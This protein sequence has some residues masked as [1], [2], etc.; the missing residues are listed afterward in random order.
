MKMVVNYLNFV[1]LIEVK[2]KSKNRIFYFC[3]SFYEKHKM[4]LWVHGL[5]CS[6]KT[7]PEDY[8]ENEVFF[9]SFFWQFFTS[10]LKIFETFRERFIFQITGLFFLFMFGFYTMKPRHVDESS[11]R[12]KQRL[13]WKSIHASVNITKIGNFLLSFSTVFILVEVR[14]NGSKNQSKSC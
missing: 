14:T 12:T 1:F 4:A 5:D 9:S 2:A 10:I 3:F 13:Y 7:L 11:N 6:L 8:S